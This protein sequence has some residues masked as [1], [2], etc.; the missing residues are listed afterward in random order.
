MLAVSVLQSLAQLARDAPN[1]DKVCLLTID[2][3]NLK[4]DGRYGYSTLLLRDALLKEDHV[5]SLYGMTCL[6]SIRSVTGGRN[7][8]VTVPLTWTCEIG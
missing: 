4:G 5:G 1:K 7:C 8:I 6:M 3:F 2:L